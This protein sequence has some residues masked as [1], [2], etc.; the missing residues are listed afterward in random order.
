M[1]TAE[2]DLLHCNEHQNEE[3]Y[4]AA[5]GAGPGMITN[6]HKVNLV[7]TEGISQASPG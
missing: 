4:W 2:G 5:R 3:L 7:V 1:V 6:M